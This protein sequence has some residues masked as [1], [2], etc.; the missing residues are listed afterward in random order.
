M[1]AD[2]WRDRLPDVLD[3]VREQSEIDAARTIGDNLDEAKK[4]LKRVVNRL[5]DGDK[6]PDASVADFVKLA[7]YI[8]DFD[9]Q[10]RT[11]IAG[12][13]LNEVIAELTA[14][15]EADRSRIIGNA[16]AG[17]GITD[18]DTVDRATKVWLGRQHSQD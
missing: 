10:A 5:G 15:T 11:A 8:D 16:L 2:K 18:R 12:E 3:K 14:G 9:S 6:L 1:R 4:L 17:L 7:R 13:L